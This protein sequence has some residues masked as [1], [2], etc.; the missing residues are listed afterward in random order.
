MMFCGVQD[1]QCIPKNNALDA[2]A[3]RWYLHANS[4]AFALFS[5]PRI[6]ARIEGEGFCDTLIIP[7]ML[8]Q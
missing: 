7:S 2:V 6:L 3:V 4:L 1:L 8:G 5:C